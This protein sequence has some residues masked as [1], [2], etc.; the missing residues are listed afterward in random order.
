MATTQAQATV[1]GTEI[2]KRSAQAIWSG[3]LASGRGML[4]SGNGAL[5][6]LPVTS[7]ALRV[8]AAITVEA[9]LEG[10]DQ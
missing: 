8:I 1:D 2:A 10:G 9:S 7:S 5:G 6:E 3:R 4:T